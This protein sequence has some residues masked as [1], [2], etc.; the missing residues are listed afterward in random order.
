MLSSREQNAAGQAPS[1]ADLARAGFI[2][3]TRAQ[4][5]LAETVL[6]PLLQAIPMGQLLSDLSDSPDPD[7][8]TLALVRLCEASPRPEQL[9]QDLKHSPR[10]RRRLLALLGASSALGD[11]L[12]AHPDSVTYLD[13]EFN[14]EKVAAT[15]TSRVKSALEAGNIP[16]AVQALRLGYYQALCAIAAGDLTHPQPLQYMPQVGLQL[17]QLADA[18]VTA[19]LPIAYRKAGASDQLAFCVIAMG[20]TGAR[21]LNYISDVD[22]MYVVGGALDETQATALGSAVASALTEI[23][24]GVGTLAPLWPLDA[25]LRPEGKDGVLVRSI[26]SYRSYYTKWAQS[27]EFQAL[28][29]ARPM[30]GDMNLG[31]QFIDLTTPLVWQASARENFVS[32]AQAM[33]RRVEKESA[34]T[35][36]DRRI[37][38]GPGGLRDVE[39]T[40]QLLQLVH[41]RSDTHLRSAATLEALNELIDGGYIGRSAGQAMSRCYRFERLIEHRAQLSRLR[42]THD[43]PKKEANLRRI[44]RSI[45]T[46]LE[47]KNLTNATELEKAFNRTRRQVRT[48]HEEI[49]YR[50]LLSAT[51]SLSDAEMRLSPQ[52]ARERLAAFGYRDPDG[53]MRQIEALTEGLSRRA[54]ILRQLLPVMIGWMGMGADPDQGLLSFRRLSD[55]IGSSH[56]FMGMLRDSRLV[57]KRLSYICSGSRWTSDR[58][59]ETPQA[60]SW[61]DDDADLQMRPREVLA[62]EVASLLRRRLLGMH[63]E[64]YEQVATQAISALLAIRSREQL[65]S[66]MADTLDGVDPLR[67]AAALSQV[68]EVVLDGAMR[69]AHAVAIAQTQ[70]PQ[71][72]EKGVDE[73][74]HLLAAHAEHA[75]IAMGRLGGAELSYASDT[76]VLF[77]HRPRPGA[78]TTQAQTEADQLARWLIS[79]LKTD[80]MHAL[81]LDADLRPEGRNGA[82]SRS[83]DA[84][85]EYYERWG[86]VWERQA[87]I[88]A[89]YIA[90]SHTVGQLFTELIAPL[91]YSTKGLNTDELRQVRHLKARMETERLPRGTNPRRH[92]KLGPGGLSD[93][94]WAV[95]LLQL[96]HAHTHPELQTTS[97]LQ[98][99]QAA[100]QAQLINQ[101]DTQ[102]LRQAWLAASRL[103]SANVL[104]TGRTSGYR[105]ELLP[106]T[107]LDLRM[108]ARLLYYPAGQ[109][110]QVEEDYLRA[111]RH[112]RTVVEKL[113]FTA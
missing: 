68:T 79:A 4:R 20:K 49:F 57:A 88:R 91:R 102:T 76:D 78:T 94:E 83:L 107:A 98:A 64:N 60:V 6:T 61:L 106:N 112:A 80:A 48:L 104:A 59:S 111:A 110:A 38:L 13:Q 69:V 29:K 70:G 26:D 92:L 45:G 23:I 34:K 77:V 63:S 35:R 50:P 17:S 99:L 25:A 18:A 21:E 97:T 42:R 66:A 22:V 46:D 54:A 62:G 44:A 52:A 89:R 55:A 87:L 51:A 10:L 11:F 31:Q 8:A 30:A 5:L 86:Q 56:W 53:A 96:R 58:L 81:V 12:I 65:R 43:L 74:G 108:V 109:D 32:D 95:Q 82:L 7:Q 47:G 67:G 33:R 19:A 3:T 101:T 37:K 14:A 90:G 36:D 105:L 103:R 72:L 1:R 75:L 39:F 27:W 84:Y 15:M 73:A 40:V 85:R 9:A 93:V 16:D 71:A 2:N 113:L 41:G 100:N 28:L 24:S